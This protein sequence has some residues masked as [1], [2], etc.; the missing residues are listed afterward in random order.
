MDGG[1]DPVNA[2]D[3]AILRAQETGLGI[4]VYSLVAIF[5]WPSSSRAGF[6]AATVKLASIQHQLY[7]AY[8]DLMQMAKEMPGKHSRSRHRRS[9]NRRASASCW[10]RRR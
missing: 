9:R 2:F 6:E 3:T 8:L 1:P 4:L 7:R 5:L 10:M